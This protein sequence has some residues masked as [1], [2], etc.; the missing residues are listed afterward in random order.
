MP[1]G[2]INYISSCV[3]LTEEFE[4]TRLIALALALGLLATTASAQ[5]STTFRDASGRTTGTATTSGSTTTYRDSS[6][7]T[8]GTATTTGNQTTIRD[9]GG[10]VIGRETTTGT[11][12][13][14]RR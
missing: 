11:P 6:G 5:T 10:R 13:A 4:V 14:P 12:G 1:R 3:G 9:S 7:R 8:T 2:K